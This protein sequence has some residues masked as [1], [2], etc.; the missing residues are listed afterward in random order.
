MPSSRV[1]SK[2]LEYQ[3]LTKS[4]IIMDNLNNNHEY[5]ASVS[6]LALSP[7]FLISTV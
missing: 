5:Y 3:I 4:Q 7:L 1:M 6:N 2:Q